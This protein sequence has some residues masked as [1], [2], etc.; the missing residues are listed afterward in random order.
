MEFDRQHFAKDWSGILNRPT[1]AN[2][3]R[4]KICRRSILRI[5]NI[6]PVC[7]VGIAL[8]NYF[9]WSRTVG[10]GRPTHTEDAFNSLTFVVF[11]VV[12]LSAYW[13][14]KSWTARKN[15]LLVAGYLFYGAWRHPRLPPYF[16]L[17]ER[18]R[19][20]RMVDECAQLGRCRIG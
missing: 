19:R 18:E 6:A 14:L 16:G 5:D 13:T 20:V 8:E 11:F 7:G 3:V 17:V 10:F 2:S 9:P 4:P 12:V 1:L 15:L